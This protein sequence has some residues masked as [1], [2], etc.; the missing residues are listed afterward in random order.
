MGSLPNAVAFLSSCAC[1]GLRSTMTCSHNFFRY[2]TGSGSCLLRKTSNDVGR[3][4]PISFKL[5]LEPSA[6]LWLNLIIVTLTEF[7]L[8]S[9]SFVFG[10]P[11]PILFSSAS[12]LE[13]LCSSSID[14]P[15][16]LAIA[17]ASRFSKASS[18]SSP[19]ESDLYSPSSVR[20]ISSRPPFVTTSP[21]N[22]SAA[23][24]QAPWGILL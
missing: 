7:S 24:S 4:C 12:S 17:A 5:S 21:S 19:A 3:E 1:G 22:S 10:E 20:L 6:E 11:E 2:V 23:V 14:Y 9:L 16:S 18:T 15:T 13:S 8:R